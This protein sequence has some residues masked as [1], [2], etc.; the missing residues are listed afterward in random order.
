MK[1][2]VGITSFG[3]KNDR[4]LSV[5][6]EQYKSMSH[7]V[8]IVVF[9]NIQR[10]LDK[11]IEVV[12]GLPSENPWSL[13]F[14]HK[15][16]FAERVDAYDLFIYTENDILIKENNIEAFLRVTS[17]L[18]EDKIAGFMLYEDD[19]LNKKNH[20]NVHGGFHWGP[21]SVMSIGDYTFAHFTN[22][23]SACYLLTREQLKKAIASG[24]YLTPP[25]EGKYDLLCTAAT[26]PYTRCG[27]TKV[28][29][30]SHFEDF[31]LHHLPN[32][33]VGKY[34][35]SERE[36]RS[37]MQAL[38]EVER[39]KRPQAE[40]LERVNINRPVKRKKL[41]YEPCDE[42]VLSHVSREI[43][44]VLSICCGSA[45]TESRLVEKGIECDC[46][47][48]D[49][50]IGAVAEIKGV[51]TL[52][53]DF[54]KSLN[55]IADKKYDCIVMLNILQH[56]DNPFDFVRVCKHLL[57]PQGILIG[58]IPNE[59][60]MG[61]FFPKR[62]KTGMGSD[63]MR[64]YHLH[65]ILVG[66]LKIIGSKTSRYVSRAARVHLPTKKELMLWLKRN[67]MQ[68]TTINYV[69]DNL[70]QKRRRIAVGPLKALFADKLIFV[71]RKDNH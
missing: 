11:S 23:H 56:V 19:S 51:R 14:A 31:E 20:V 24:G 62:Y 53:P 59:D 45:E 64:Y 28:I 1:I 18:P 50:V 48:L 8:D 54:D 35:I 27:F 2:L 36:F 38:L 55:S 61:D 46:I 58:T 39:G 30:V 47:P 70:S 3:T 52:Y 37:Q 69:T 71:A 41:Y 40:F 17:I 33:Y 65:D 12:V 10:T 66:G 16:F 32:A 44:N 22:E 9:S 4:Y 67:G 57:S 42:T 43:K 34:G 13:P 5:L 60:Y 29:C 26:D 7:D 6:I 68:I 21:K 25:R 15:S 49:S 63:R